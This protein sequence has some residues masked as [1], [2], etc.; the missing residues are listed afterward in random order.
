VTD[1][2]FSSIVKAVMWGR[3]INDTIS[4]FLQFQ[5]TV[6]CV[7]VTLVF[8]GACTIRSS[9]L[10]A[11][12][13]LW[14]N[15]VMDSLGSLALATE[16]PTRDLLKRKPYGRTARLVSPIM[17]RNIIG[18]T[19]YQLTILLVFVFIGDK[20]FNIPSGRDTPIN[21]APTK[22]F[23]IIF[24]SLM[25]MTLFNEIN[26]RK[27]HDERNVFKGL[28]T[29]RIYCVIWIL[30]LTLHVLIVQFGGRVF[31]TAR[32]DWYE[33]LVCAGLGIGSLIWHQIV[34]SIP[35]R[36]LF[37]AK[38]ADKRTKS[39]EKKNELAELTLKKNG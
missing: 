3:N 22:H 21:S 15:L 35:T 19:I 14:V 26:A 38:K 7:A 18:H 28:L 24:N 36:I 11:V 30:S 23:T 33:W 2:N 10:K 4:K 39:L 29:N 32:L 37:R 20:L 6:T 8:V 34:V 16:T 5:L 27:I 31:S 12:Q 1:D 17:A 9:P 25:F 13:M